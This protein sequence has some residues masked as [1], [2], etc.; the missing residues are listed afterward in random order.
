MEIAIPRT[1]APPFFPLPTSHPTQSRLTYFRDI[2]IFKLDAQEE[3]GIE[4]Q[5]IRF[6]LNLSLEKI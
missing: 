6:Y 1:F 5:Y 3:I 2:E 4:I